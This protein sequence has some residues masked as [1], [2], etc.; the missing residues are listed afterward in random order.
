MVANITKIRIELSEG[1]RAELER[2]G[3]SLA[4]PHRKVVRARTILL[5]AAGETVS[6][7]S[8]KVGRQRKHVR[9]WAQRFLRKR[10]RGLD[11]EPRSGRPPV[12]SPRGGDD[13]G[14][15]GVRAA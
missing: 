8:R 2:W 12:F 13:L 11:D 3:R 6:A 1:E 4:G 9:K 15:A 14:E 10:L 5:L 7:V